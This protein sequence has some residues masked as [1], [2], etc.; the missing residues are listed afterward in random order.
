VKKL[1]LTNCRV[2]SPGVD[3]PSAAIEI[4]GEMIVSVHLETTPSAPVDETIDL[5]GRM[6]LPGFVDIHTHGAAG[7]DVCDGSADSVRRIARA[8]LAEGVTTFL[9]TTLTLA[10]EALVA[11]LQHVAGY[12]KNQ[13]FARTPCVHIEGPFINPKCVGAQNPKF[14]RPPDAAELEQLHAIAPAGIVSVAVEMPG[15]IEFVRKMREMGIVTSLAHTAATYADFRRAKDAGLR[16]LTHFCNQM[17]PLHHREIGIVGAGLLDPDI[18]IE[19]ICDRIHLAPE[20]IALVFALKPL[21][22]LMLI[23]DSIAASHLGDGEFDIGGLPVTVK[24]GQA[25]LHSGALAGSTL[26][27]NDALR[28]VHQITGLPLQELVA[29]TSWNQAR[30]LGLRDRGRLEPGYLADIAV[31][32]SDFSVSSV[33]VGGQQHHS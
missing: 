16:H 31:L 24:D 25:R 15:G 32:D 18:M 14:V 29:T 26:R 28:N 22:Q 3:L 11:A 21:S 9:P 19:L 5:Q 17:T 2:I 20:M 30:S 4:H 6:A 7:A 12:R 33:F 13:E 23:T 10:H 1:L 27:M 8:K